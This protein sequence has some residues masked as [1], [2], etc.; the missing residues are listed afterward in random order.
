MY[1]IRTY[2]W[3]LRRKYLKH[4]IFGRPWCVLYRDIQGFTRNCFRVFTSKFGVLLDMYSYSV[5]HLYENIAI[6]RYK[7][8]FFQTKSIIQPPINILWATFSLCFN[9]LSGEPFGPDSQKYLIFRE[10]MQFS[11][12]RILNND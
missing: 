12:I 8:S 6:I 7:E 4:Q 3:S 10:K 2:L 9:F 5:T 1:A 11:K